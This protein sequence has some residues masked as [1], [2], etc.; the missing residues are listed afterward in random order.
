MKLHES[1][2]ENIK[3]VQGWAMKMIRGMEEGFRN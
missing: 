3:E 2:L 1:T